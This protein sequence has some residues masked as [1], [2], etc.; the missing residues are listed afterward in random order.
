MR[1][2]TFIVYSA[3]LLPL[4]LFAQVDSSSMAKLSDMLEQYY[5]AMLF[6]DNAVKES[7]CDYLIESCKDFLVG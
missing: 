6:E 1:K 2:I 7:E 3:L 4:S 5:D